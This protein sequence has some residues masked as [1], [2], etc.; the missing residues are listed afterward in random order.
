M[1]RSRFFEMAKI[2]TRGLVAVQLWVGSAVAVENWQ[3][4]DAGASWESVGELIGLTA[5]ASVLMPAV[6]DTTTNAL[7]GLGKR[8]GSIE[9]P[10]SRENLTPLLTDGKAATFWSVPRD[11]RPDG[12]S[13][14]IDLGAI[15][16]IKR[17]RIIGDPEIFLRAYELFVHDGDPEQL[18]EG[19]PVAFTNMVGSNLEQAESIIDV[20][21]PLQFVRFIRLISRS[22]QE[23][24]IEDAEVFGDGFAP[25]GSFIS[26]I[27]DL[28]NPA[29]FGK[30]VLQATSDSLTGIVLQTRTGL[31]PDPRV[32]YRKTD[33]FEGEDRSEDP[34]FPIGFPAAAEEYDDLVSADK[35]AIVD[36]IT[37][38]SPWSAP[39]EDFSGNLLS[40]G[41]R[42]FLQF[43]LFFSSEN[44]RH[45][46]SVDLFSLEYSIPTLAQELTAEVTPAAVTLGETHTFDYF[47]RSEFAA[48]NPGFDRVE[49]KTPF[50][51]S[52]REVE[53]DGGSIPFAEEEDEEG[54]L[55]VL[56]TADRVENSGQVLHITFD[57]LVTVY[58]TTFFGKVFDSQSEELGQNVVAGDASPA[59]LSNRLSIQGALSRE[60]VMDLQV[61]PPAF[62]PNG[63]GINDELELSFILLR[64]L[65]PVPVEITLFDLSGRTVRRL[66]TR[67]MMNG[68][69]SVIWN[70]RGDGGQLVPP[71][72]YLLKLSVD[73]DTGSEEQTRLVGVAY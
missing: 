57:A 61:T 2:L 11:R 73:T 17:V 22:S 32:F 34:I 24:T 12:T 18:R 52:I 25:T 65:N 19:R 43:R 51:A 13:M 23:F 59:S 60:L 55:N 45:G 14:L 67:G 9:S 62:S 64:A 1:G 33:V 29:N 48:D 38:W 21:F 30:L 72:L 71:G 46:S 53:L 50:N 6:V 3:A 68:P 54:N 49:I 63:D 58:G 16:P 7:T 40:P 69:Q 26:D 27:I 66:Q 10:Q 39:Y 47:L 41:N 42:R 56:L 5:D 8:G 70:G 44:A 36:N 20:Q 37:E 28:G 15:L 4:G 35:G 31:V